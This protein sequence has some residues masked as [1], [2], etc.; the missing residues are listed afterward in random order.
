MLAAAKAARESS[1]R[2]GGCTILEVGR[3]KDL[4]G[5][6]GIRNC[7]PGGD[8][9]GGTMGQ[10]WGKPSA[11]LCPSM[12]FERFAS[13]Y[14]KAPEPIV[15]RAWALFSSILQHNRGVC[16]EIRHSGPYSGWSGGKFRN[17]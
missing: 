3:G 14:K 11:I 12:P 15:C 16:G 10:K 4:M 13:R 17:R 8:S 2:G 5:T 1:W 9:L 7:S 6:L